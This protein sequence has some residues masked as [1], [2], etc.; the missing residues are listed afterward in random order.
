MREMEVGILEVYRISS[1]CL[2][3]LSLPNF[4]LQILL[5]RNLKL[6]FWGMLLLI[7]P[8][9]HLGQLL[10]VTPVFATLDDSITIVYNAS[11]GNGELAGVSPVYAHM[12]LITSQSTG[13]SDW[14]YV[15]GNWGTADARVLMQDLGNNRH[16]IKISGRDFYGIP[17]GET[18]LQLSFVFRN[19]DGNMVGRDADGSDIYYEL[20]QGSG[21]ASLI[22]TPVEGQLVSQGSTVD[23]R[24]EVA[25]AASLSLSVNGT[26]VSTSTGKS[27]SYAYTASQAGINEVLLSINTGG[28]LTE[29]STFFL[30]PAPN[31]VMDPPAGTEPG[32][33]YVDDSTVVLALYAPQKSTVFAIGD[34]NGWKP[35][36]GSQMAQSVD[37]NTYW[38][39]ITGLE[40]GREYV[41][42]YL[43]D[44]ITKIADPFADKILD[45]SNDPFISNETY[46]N[47]IPFP[48]DKT[49]GRAAVF[50]TAQQPYAWQDSAYERP[51]QTELVIYELLVRDFVDARNFQTVLDSLDYLTELGVNAIEFMPIMEFENN[52]SWG[53]NPSFFFAVDKYYGTKNSLKAFID[54]CHARGIAVILDM[55]LNHA[56][57]QNEYVR[58]YP[59]NDNPF[60]NQSPTHPFNVGT[61]FNH[62]SVHTRF[63]SKKVLEYWVEEYHFDGYRMDLSKGFTQK[64]NPDNVGAWG[65]YDATRI[66]I[67]TDYFNHLRSV[68]STA[69]FILEHFAE[70]QEEIELANL[71]MMLWGNHTHNYGEATMGYHDGGKSNFRGISYKDRGFQEPHLVGYMESHDEERLMYKNLTFGNASGDYS[72]QN[73]FVALERNEMAGAFFYTIPG[74]K[75]LWMFGEYGYDYSIDFNG[76]VGEKPVR[77]DYFAPG[78]YHR[79]HLYEVW[80]ALIKLRR[81]HPVFNTEDF[82]LNVSG[83]VK[84]IELNHPDMNVFIIGNFGV[85]SKTANTSFQSS[86]MWYDYFSGDSVDV[87]DPNGLVS[88]EPGEWHLYT[89][90]KLNSPGVTVSNEKVLDYDPGSVL[91]YPNPAKNRM[92]LTWEGGNFGQVQAAVFG[93]DGRLI[94]QLG[95]I[96]GKKQVEWNLQNNAGQRVAPGLYLIQLITDKGIFTKK[97]R[98]EMK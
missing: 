23:L 15:Q 93:L 75:M 80:A 57:G 41:Y 66:A 72:T 59:A 67:L 43:V 89:D 12:G 64:N 35:V 40:P 20:Y 88:L 63:F 78:A 38:L 6:F 85:E 87:S 79:R 61:D 56:F 27:I 16:Q 31:T 44:G 22:L 1:M 65:A 52:N 30:V 74:P 14:K 77:W 45:E 76:R 39:E 62:E 29:D 69:Y 70:R 81:S 37:G 96:P 68:D 2:L 42:Q 17:Q 49:G 71:G 60:F 97:V 28:T 34:F 48:S 94:R 58:M 54:S 55:V 7:V 83:E 90:V 25:Q 9:Y 73:L 86:G 5:M 24:A 10:E 98:V 19:E 51:K 18:A 26:Q 3:I 33:N 95:A 32:I 47:L 84:R 8:K 21:Q 53:Y 82:A 91:V 36:G 92:N 4:Q 50:Q 46:P 13:P 11:Q